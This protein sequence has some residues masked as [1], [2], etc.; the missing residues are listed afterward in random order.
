MIR[1][2]ASTISIP[3]FRSRG[4]SEP[5]FAKLNSVQGGATNMPYT[6]S[7]GVYVQTSCSGNVITLTSYPASLYG[8]DHAPVPPH[9]S[10]MIF[11]P[12]ILFLNS[13]LFQTFSS[14]AAQIAVVIFWSIRSSKCPSIALSAFCAMSSR[15]KRISISPTVWLCPFR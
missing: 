5:F 12:P 1:I 3:L 15:I 6:F 14:M 4:I 13:F 10:R 8:L 11:S 9:K 7:G 2:Q